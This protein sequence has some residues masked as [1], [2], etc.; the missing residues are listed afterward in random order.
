MVCPWCGSGRVI[1]KG[2][3]YGKQRFYC[4]NC[5]KF[6]SE[7]PVKRRCYLN[8]Y[9]IKVVKTAIRIRISETRR[10]FGHSTST[11][12]QWMKELHEEIKDELDK[13]KKGKLRRRYWR[14]KHT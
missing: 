10:I 14:K 4:K 5:G 2:K 13:I 12:Y 6:F 1:R 7:N 9:K 3:P 11:I 8:E